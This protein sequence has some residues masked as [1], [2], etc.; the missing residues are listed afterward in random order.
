M[1]WP[2]RAYLV[3][4]LV[5]GW[6]LAGLLLFWFLAWPVALAIYLP[7]AAASIWFSWVTARVLDR[8]PTTGKEAMIGLEGEVVRAS[9]EPVTVRV[10]GELWSARARGPVRPGE[11]VRV[12]SIEGLSL[13]V[14]P[15]GGTGDLRA[16]GPRAP[17]E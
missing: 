10:R 6:P 14:E 8:C 7:V 2:A 1:K 15:A 12:R 16:P 3:F 9:P 4:Q 13:V 17:G 11:R 5:S